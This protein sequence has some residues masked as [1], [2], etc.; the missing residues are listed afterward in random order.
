MMFAQYV[1]T[2]AF[3]GVTGGRFWLAQIPDDRLPPNNVI[4]AKAGIHNAA[5]QHRSLN[6][7]TGHCIAYGFPL[8]RECRR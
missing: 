2:L 1:W 6:G 7:G 4:P 3:A 8:S 5:R